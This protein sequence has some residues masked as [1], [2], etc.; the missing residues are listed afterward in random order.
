MNAVEMSA[1]LSRPDCPSAPQWRPTRTPSP[2]DLEG[3]QL[4]DFVRRHFC[5][6]LSTLDNLLRYLELCGASD[7]KRRKSG[8][9][10][11]LGNLRTLEEW[12]VK[13]LASELSWQ[14]ESVRVKAA[15]MSTRNELR[16]YSWKVARVLHLLAGA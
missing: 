2:S 11:L 6:G 10:S 14:S 16:Q 4:F 1:R 15:L 8:I 9:D 13:F 12:L 5:A 3:I 7:C